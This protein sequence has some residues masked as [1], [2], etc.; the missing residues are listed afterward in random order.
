ME[1]TGEFCDANSSSTCRRRLCR[2]TADSDT[3]LLQ[4]LA[5]IRVA[6]QGAEKR[7]AIRQRFSP[8]ACDGWPQFSDGLP[9]RLYHVA[10]SLSDLFDQL[11]GFQMQISN[12]GLLHVTHC[13]ASEWLK[14][15]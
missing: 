7:L 12:S 1:S 5:D 14:R 2:N 15:L 9:P 6:G 4:D 3:I 11:A 13:D 10:L 8:A